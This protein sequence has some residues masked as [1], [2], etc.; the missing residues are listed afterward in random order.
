MCSCS[1]AGSH[2][3]RG[4]CNQCA[5]A[6]VAK[7]GENVNVDDTVVSVSHWCISEQATCDAG[8][9]AIKPL[10]KTATSLVRSD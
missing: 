6:L 5:R 9:F 7:R 1:G 3:G 10:G 2:L 4:G 8:H